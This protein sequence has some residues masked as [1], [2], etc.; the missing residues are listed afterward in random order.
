LLGKQQ[1]LR[2]LLSSDRFLHFSYAAVPCL[3]WRRIASERAKQ[4]VV[5][6]LSF[7]IVLLKMT[8]FDISRY[9]SYSMWVRWA[10]LQQSNVKFLQDS[11]CQKWLK[12]VHFWL[13]Y[14]KKMWA[15]FGTHCIYLIVYIYVYMCFKG[16]YKWL[17]GRSCP[18]IVF[19]K[20]F[21]HSQRQD[22]Y[23]KLITWHISSLVSRPLLSLSYQSLLVL[24]YYNNKW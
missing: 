5:T 22:K 3:R 14:S 12:S 9:S 23:I 24:Q 4:R 8:F 7:P 11:V 17:Y 21:I 16:K 13:S 18:V 1:K 10:N 20:S 2:F 6:W 15:F 19:I